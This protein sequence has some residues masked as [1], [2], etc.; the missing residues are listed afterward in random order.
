MITLPSTFP[1]TSHTDYVGVGSTFVAIQGHREN[2]VH[3]IP[4][5]LERGATTIVLEQNVVLPFEIEAS[6]LQKKAT[7]IR[8]SN[9]R[10]A[11]AQLSA[12]S[13]GFPAKKL[14][15]IAITGTVGKTTSAFLVEHLLRSLRHKTALLSSV[16]N[17]ILETIF[18]TQLTTQQ[19]D[20][21]HVFLQQ[22]VL[23]NIDYVV[24]EVAAQALSLDR[25][26]DIE[27]DAILFTNFDREHG[28]FYATVEE[29]F[30][31]KCKIFEHRK[32]NAPVLINRDNAWCHSLLKANTDF[33]NF[34]CQDQQASYYASDISYSLHGTQ[35]FIHH[36]NQVLH[37]S[38]A[39]IGAFNAYNILGALALCHALDNSLAD[40]IRVLTNFYAVPGRL[41]LISM[42]NGARACIDYAYNPF[43]YA[44]V[45]KTLRELSAHMIV[46]C[47]A[48]GDRDKIRRPSMGALAAQFADVVIFTADNPRSEDPA[49]IVQE[50]IAGVDEQSLH[51]ISIELDRELA[52]KKAYSLSSENSI[53]VLL[54]KGPDHYQLIGG[55]KLYFNETEILKSIINF[56]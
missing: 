42:P 32:Q 36:N 1:V 24:M 17:K 5:A 44:S 6:I 12:E 34:G 45:L 49:V 39:L 18:T 48:G 15:I 21:L 11:L 9:T 20:Y 29:Y 52:I 23:E 13:L 38:S 2:G 54:G 51:K 30:L 33:F 31:A 8:V 56:K 46:V 28:E 7:I 25:V 22:C 50:M 19:P 16:H 43:S 35:G 10:K 47:G 3:Y 37:F 53:I 4:L 14:K 26:H 41:E 55:K 27:F 40:L